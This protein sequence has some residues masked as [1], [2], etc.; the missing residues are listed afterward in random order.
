VEKG[1]YTKHRVDFD[2]FTVSFF[3]PHLFFGNIRASMGCGATALSLL[4]GVPPEKIAAKNG[5]RHFS[6]PFM[7]NFLRRRG[8]SV[9]ELTL[10]NVSAGSG[11]VS[12]DH[13]VLLSQL[14]MRNEGTW[15]AIYRNSF[16]HNFEL[17]DLDR[18]T[19]LN[20]PIL[21]AYLVVHPAWRE[22]LPKEE[23]LKRPQKSKKPLTF[24]DLGVTT[25]SS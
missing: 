9:A 17:Y 7:V 2:S 21:S 20:K 25:R 12:K 16:Y 23:D 24:V 18:L 15:G 8:F 22:N 5:N 1:L 14:I 19:F 3:N 6:D 10:C 4:T 13:V 11:K